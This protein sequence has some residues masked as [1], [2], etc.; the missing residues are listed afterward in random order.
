MRKKREVSRLY[1]K[2]KN[3]KVR[4]EIYIEE[5][6]KWKKLLKE[7]RREKKRREKEESWGIQQKSGN[8]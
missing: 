8:T 7:K 3:R 2:W 6:R 4:R 5:R 1:R